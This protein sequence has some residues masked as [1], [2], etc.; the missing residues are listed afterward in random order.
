MRETP[1]IQMFSNQYVFYE[2]FFHTSPWNFPTG[3][4]QMKKGPG[5][6]Q[7]KKVRSDF[8][9]K[10]GPSDCQGKKGLCY[11]TVKVKKDHVTLR[12]KGTKWLSR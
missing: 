6:C 12:V 7:G 3:S 4:F 8:Q 10:K 11:V 9:G 1:I 5:E 2:L